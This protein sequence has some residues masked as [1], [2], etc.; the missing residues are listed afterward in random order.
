MVIVPILQFLLYFDQIQDCYFKLKGDQEC[1]CILILQKKPQQLLYC[2]V[3]GIFCNCLWTCIS[4]FAVITVFLGVL[5]HML[6][7]CL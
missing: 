1:K 3:V 5:A 7:Y 6:L 4:R 2:I